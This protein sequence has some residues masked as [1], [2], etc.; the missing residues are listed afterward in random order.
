MLSGLDPG[1][2]ADAGASGAVPPPLAEVG[3]AALQRRP[4]RGCPT[5]R[6]ALALGAER[7]GS[8][9]EHAGAG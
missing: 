2:R 8:G 7:T 5:I 6:P 3:I 1:G 9:D 4:H